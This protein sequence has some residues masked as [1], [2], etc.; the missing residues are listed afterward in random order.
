VEA[1]KTERH[2]GWTEAAREGIVG[3]VISGIASAAVN[4]LAVGMPHSEAANA[5]NNGLSG[6]FSG[7]FTGFIG[8]LV[9]FRRLGRKEQP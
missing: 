5:I 1:N 9:L 8:T 4:Y 3:G 6:C 2:S 7:F